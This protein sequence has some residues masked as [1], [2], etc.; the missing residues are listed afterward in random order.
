MTVTGPRQSG[1]TVLCRAALP[2][3]AYVNLEA[4]NEREFA[5]SDPVGFLARFSDGAILDEIQL[6]PDL[7]SYL[8][9]IADEQRRNGLFVLSG[10]EQFRLSDAIGQSLAGR[11]ALLRLLLFTLAERALALGSTTSSTRAATRGYTTSTL[12]RPRRSATTSRP[13]WSATCGASGRSATWGRSGGSC[14]SAPRGSAESPS[15]QLSAPTPSST[16][17]A[18][19]SAAAPATS[20]RSPAWLICSRNSTQTA[21]KAGAAGCSC[22]IL[23]ADPTRASSLDRHRLCTHGRGAGATPARSAGR[24]LLVCHGSQLHFPIHPII[25]ARLPRRR[26]AEPLARRTREMGEVMGRLTC[27]LASRCANTRSAPLHR[28]IRLAPSN[29]SRRSDQAASRDVLRWH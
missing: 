12:T 17:A 21:P 28:G 9:V 19:T 8:Q 4:P 3:R 15:C 14:A 20:S 25:S 13:T 1:K 11:T 29:G 22:L 7:L 6:A 5:L 18:T 16:A 23:A 10:S 24:P 26:P 2:H 27:Y